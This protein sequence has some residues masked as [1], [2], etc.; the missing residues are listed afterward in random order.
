[1][2]FRD[3]R[4]PFFTVS[5]VFLGLIFFFKIYG[6][7][8][9]SV[10]SI[11][12]TKDTL[13]RVDGTGKATVVPDTAVIQ[14]GVTQSATKVADAQNKTNQ[15]TNKIVED[16]KRLGVKEKDIKTTNY[17]VNPDYNYNSDG[18]KP[19]ITGYTVT[20]N[21]QA[22][23][24]PIDLA[25]KVVDTATADG[26]NMVGNIAFTVNDET[27]K[28]LEDQAREEA[29]KNAKEKAAS[30]AKA[31]GIS[32]GRIVDVQESGRGYPIPLA[33]DRQMM[34]KTPNAGGEPTQLNPGESSIE[35]T[36][37]LSYETR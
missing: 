13:F 8:P 4:T 27:R 10:N 19:K 9:F 37:T 33:Y 24:K 17:S 7:I 16:L 14:L 3:L 26:A 5:F 29:V 22:E 20:V 32:L 28:E 21:I 23:V 30:L 25:N 6:A 35:L 18:S 15:A 1:M 31:A 11:Q 2:N 34:S 12:T 36:V